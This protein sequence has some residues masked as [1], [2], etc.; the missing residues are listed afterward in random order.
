MAQAITVNPGDTVAQLLKRKRGLK[1]QEVLL[2]LPKVRRINPHIS[3]LD[4]IHPREKVLLPDHLDETVSDIT[5]W[6]NAFGHIP[7]ALS[8]NGHGGQL[9]HLCSGA[10]SIDD[11]ARSMFADTPFFHLPHSAKRA[12]LIHNNPFL[13]SHLNTNMVPPRTLVDI[14]PKR[15]SD[16]DHHFWNSQRPYITVAWDQLHKTSKQVVRDAGTEGGFALAGLVKHLKEVGAGVGMDDTVQFAGYGVAGVSGYAASGQ[17]AIGNTQALARELYEEAI[18]KFGRQV[19]QSK[20]KTNLVKMQRFLTGHPKYRQL[21][22]SLKELPEHLL[23]K[24]RRVP[25]PLS[26]SP[27]ATARH[28]RKAFSLPYDKWN[29]SRY[30]STIGRQLNGKVRLLKGVG[31]HATWYIPAAF[32]IYNVVQA[33]AELRIRAL[34]EEGFGVVGGAFGTMIGS[35][36]VATGVIGVLALCGLCI[37]PFGLCVIVFLC[38][39]AGGILGMEAAKNFGAEIYDY[40]AKFNHDKLF[41]SSEEFLMEAK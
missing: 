15:F 36:M 33:P 3:N 21:M 2:W 7:P 6:Q 10:E 1:E 16:M 22:Q 30:F 24:G 9:M 4:L 12:L 17:M 32:G 25:N 37:G 26:A 27:N 11:V 13:L 5:I 20:N 38:A 19:V 40:G 18:A 34:F 28:F 39:S 8:H 31:R 29:S 14:T 35:N 23:P 41:Y